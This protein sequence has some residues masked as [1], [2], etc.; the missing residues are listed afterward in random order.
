MTAVGDGTTVRD[1]T[2]VGDG[3]TDASRVRSRWH[4]WRW[5][6][7]L[8]MLV[9]LTAIAG[10]L[11]EPRTSG[12]PLAPDNP[13][14]RGARALAQILEREGVQVHFVRSSGE[15]TKAAVAGSTLLVTSTDLLSSDQ[16]AALAR[17]RADL[18]LLSP[19][20]DMLRA[21]THAAEVA[22]VATSSTPATRDARCADADAA[23]AGTIR[24]AGAEYVATTRAARVCFPATDPTAGS[25]LVVDG[26][27]RV[28]ALGDPELLTN[29]ALARQGNAALAL[30]MLGRHAKLTWYVPSPSDLGESA[31]GPSLGDLLPPWTG[32]VALQLALVAVVAALWRARRLGHAARTIRVS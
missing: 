12:I 7:A 24:A 13:S 31:S 3:T 14:G 18:A 6:M 17:T 10:A 27:R 22:D 1:G 8:A 4:R 25:Y 11:P 29:A 15:A 32:A 2:T 21:V 28:A 16:I 9:V 26:R 5:P 30:R 19:D 20:P 23:A